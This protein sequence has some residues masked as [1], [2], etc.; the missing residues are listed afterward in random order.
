L[1]PLYFIKTHLDQVWFWPIW[2]LQDA[3]ATHNY[4]NSMYQGTDVRLVFD[5]GA[6]DFVFKDRN[7]YDRVMSTLKTFDA[8]MRTAKTRE[9]YE[10]FVTEDDF[11][12][13][14]PQNLSEPK[15]GIARTT[16]I[17]AAFALAAAATTTLV[18]VILNADKFP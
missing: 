17:C 1:S 8:T 18:A 9:Q 6:E 16:I 4:R 14:N 15:T 10:Y 5:T 12:E 13:W 7:A 2:K 3:S 11:Q